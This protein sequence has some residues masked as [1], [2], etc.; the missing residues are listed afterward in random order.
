MTHLPTL[1][2]DHDLAGAME[3]LETQP[4]YSI[5]DE[6]A[7]MDAVSS[8]VSFRLLD[9]DRALEVFEELDPVDQQQILEGLRDQPFRD[10]VEGM[11]PDDRAR[12]LG[13]VPAKV[14][15]RVLAGLSAHERQ[16]TAAL[17]GYPEGSV[18]RYMT[19][20]TV[21]L[22][23]NL[24]VAE[25]LEVV[26]RRGARAETIYTLPVVDTGR[27]LTGIVEL[28][29]LVLG[30]PNAQVS[31][32][33]ETEP[34][35]ARATDPAEQAARLMR[36]TNVLNLPVVDSEDRLVGLLTIDDAVEVIEAADTEDV[37]RQSG[38]EPLERHYMSASVFQLSRAR[39]MWL[40]LL[41]V[42]ATLTVS[43]TQA[44][45]GE[46]ETVTQLALFIPLLIGTGGN[47]GAQAATAAVRALA[48]G[49]VRTSDLLKVIWRE[50]R[51]GLLLGLML[52][53]IGFAVGAAFVGLEIAAVVAVTLVVICAW[54]ATVGGTMPLLAKKM[55]IDP[56]VV[57]APMVTTLVDATGLIIYFSTAKLI[58]GI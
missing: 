53:V 30:D 57:S 54:A 34:Q 15:R 39:A 46:L 31:Q 14:A 18:G 41:L 55:R 48:V 43:V 24:T 56:A 47:A 2:D 28:R 21:A 42:A 36:E 5:A 20:E 17:L 23:Q 50:C 13:E 45:E 38:A 25:A 40:T 4:A 6:L 52:A 58:L 10:L 33:V 9:K 29:E 27:R 44:F 35:R 7:R 3:W 22:Q 1:L 26:R 49:E 12:M 19:P 11:D 8:V 16:M 37:A 51:T 32:L